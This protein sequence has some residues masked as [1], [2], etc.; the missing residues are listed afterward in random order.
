MSQDLLKSPTE[1]V[2]KR[3][4]S[5]LLSAALAGMM[6]STMTSCGKDDDKKTDDPVAQSANT[7]TPTVTSKTKVADLTFEKFSTDC[8]NK[9]G[10]VETHAACSGANTCKGMS[11]NKWSKELS[12]HTC[13]G[14]NTCAGMSC[15]E[16]PQDGGKSGEEIYKNECK[17][18]HGGMEN[19]TE[20]SFKVFFPKG[21]SGDL[22][23]ATFKDRSSATHVAIVAFGTQGVNKNGTA[24]SNMPAYYQKISRTE[25]EKAVDYIRTLTPVAEEYEIMGQE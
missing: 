18:C 16:L 4:S 19:S 25:I 20:N 21:G 11:F 9:S 3:P 14:I 6:G 22:A 8:K 5:R 15:V 17:G 2:K 13:K 24:F 7:A 10:L 23:I 12:E 1:E